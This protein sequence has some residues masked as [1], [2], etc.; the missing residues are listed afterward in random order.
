MASLSIPA[1]FKDLSME[2]GTAWHGR[3]HFVLWPSF[4]DM[5]ADISGARWN[6]EE[7]ALMRGQKSGMMK[8]FTFMIRAKTAE[9]ISADSMYSM[10]RNILTDII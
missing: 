3:G 9:R 1:H 10:V 6:G 2:K 8:V 4:W 5:I 7:L